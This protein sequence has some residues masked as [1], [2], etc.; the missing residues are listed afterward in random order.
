MKKNSPKKVYFLLISIISALV[1]IVFLQGFSKTRF[2][3]KTSVSEVLENQDS[4]NFSDLSYEK[5]MIYLNDQFKCIEITDALCVIDNKI[6]IGNSV[7]LIL[8]TDTF[9]LENLSLD[10]DL[11]KNTITITGS[12]WS[13]FSPFPI[14]S[15][16]IDD[17]FHEV[18]I[19]KVIES[20]KPINVYMNGKRIDDNSFDKNYFN[21]QEITDSDIND[22]PESENEITSS[23]EIANDYLQILNSSQTGQWNEVDS[24]Q[25]IGQTRLFYNDDLCWFWEFENGFQVERAAEPMENDYGVVLVGNDWILND[26]T[27]EINCANNILNILGGIKIN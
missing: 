25:D 17:G 27:R 18:T 15:S 24:N 2:I 4:M 3:E 22:A 11:S 7:G 16:Y 26:S 20:L 9:I 23:I 14:C 8:D 5:Q 10:P 21:C 12:N 6:N 19:N 13:I 1:I